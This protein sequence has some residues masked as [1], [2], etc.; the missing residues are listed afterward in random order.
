MENLQRVIVSILLVGVLTGLGLLAMR[1][2]TDLAQFVNRSPETKIAAVFGAVLGIFSVP[3]V[4]L[5]A[6]RL[7]GSFARWVLQGPP[8]FSWLDSEI[9][10]VGAVSLLI[11]IPVLVMVILRRHITRG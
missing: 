10:L 3:I 8:P 1:P 4:F 2:I 7:S 11:G 5:L 9:A 6:F